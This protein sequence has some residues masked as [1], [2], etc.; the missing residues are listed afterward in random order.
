MLKLIQYL[1]FANY[2]IGLLAVALAIETR[3]Q[4]RA[5]FNAPAFYSLLFSATV[6]F[7]T[8]AYITEQP[9]S[10]NNGNLRTRWYQQHHSFIRRSQQIFLLL[11]VAS[12]LFELAQHDLQIPRLPATYWFIIITVPL[13]G[14]LYYGVWPGLFLKTRLRNIG[15]LKPFIIGY[16]WAGAVSAFPVIMLAFEQHY[17]VQQPGLLLWLFIKNWMFCAVNA[18]MFDIKDYREDSNQQLK[19]Y[20]VRAGLQKTI[21]LILFP[22]SLIGFGSYIV[23]ATFNDFSTY[24]L[25]LNAIPFILLLLIA[26]RLNFERHIFY[27]LI[28]ID[29]LLLVKAI[30][31]I[32]AAL[33]E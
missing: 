15:W 14:L 27:Y 3:F 25:L 30:C 29:G 28:V 17:Q 5:D 7:Y 8:R 32:T 18:I 10:T 6:L 21:W 12:I 24:R 22:L 23:F 31:G 20:V 11:T 33:I 16:V 2:F 19:T 26:T 9:S 13:T 1:F 4:L